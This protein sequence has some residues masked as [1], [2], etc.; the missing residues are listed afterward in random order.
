MRSLA[1]S[2]LFII[3][4]VRLIAQNIDYP[5][6]TA[7]DFRE[8]LHDTIIEDPYRWLENYNSPEVSDWYK[9]QNALTTAQLAKIP[10]RDQLKTRLTELWTYERR[11]APRLDA[12]WYYYYKNDGNDNHDVLFRYHPSN[13]TEELVLDP[14]LLSEDGTVSLRF[15]SVSNNGQLA[16][17]GV[18]QSGSDK[19]EIR[20]MDLKSKMELSESLTGVKFSTVAWQ[21]DGFYYS[22]FD[23]NSHAAT[24][25][26]VDQFHKIYFHKAGTSQEKDILI[27]EDKNNP[28]MTFGARVNRDEN[29]L[30]ISSSKSSG[31][32][33]LKVKNLHSENDFQI[34]SDDFDHNWNVI[35]AVINKVLLI[36]SNGAPRKKIVEYDLTNSKIKTLVPQR[37][38]TLLG[39]VRA[40][41]KLMVHYMKD[42]SSRIFV[43]SLDGVFEKEL[44]LPEFC[45]VNAMNG[46]PGDSLFYFRTSGYTNPG[47]IWKYNLITGL[48]ELFYQP[49]LPNFRPDEFETRL[50]FYKSKDGTMIPMFLAGSKKTL[51]EKNKKPVL[52]YGYGGFNISKTPEFLIERIPFLEAGG[53]LALPCLRGGGEYGK[54]WHKAGTKLQKQNVFDDFI[55]AAEYLIE[56]GYTDS[57]MLAIGGRSNGG[58]LVGA[59]MTQRPGLFKVALPAVGVM[60]MLR[61]HK[62]TIGWAWTGDYG[63]PENQDEFKALLAYSPYHN[64]RKGVTYPSSLVTTADHDDRVVPSHSYKFIARLQ[65]H[66]KGTNPV[67]IRVDEAAGHGAGKP[68]VKIIDEQTDIFS[69]MMQ[70]LGMKY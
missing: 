8:L 54:E 1:L 25:D 15:F 40:G 51:A 34:I 66:H 43:Y 13:G 41:N 64:I 46:D 68:V 32:N 22:R 44:Q 5:K 37:D 33:S 61:F 58:L 67:L 12:G 57:T 20:I 4:A 35:D 21:G 19:T 70:E 42:A 7:I 9:A 31:G 2:I 3:C 45:T 24:N 47:S 52:L 28:R 59:T 39:A 6:T 17:F 16:A 10:F 53:L 26:S 55:A 49:A 14:N 29:L 60:D 30:F 56:H 11:S 23:R 38:E 48:T 27:H 36:T 50:L 18:S 69:F 63:S 62:F 65:A